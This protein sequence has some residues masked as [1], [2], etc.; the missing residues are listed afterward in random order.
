MCSSTVMR[1][2]T[3]LA[4]S[5]LRQASSRSFVLPDVLRELKVPA[6]NTTTARQCK[7]QDRFARILPTA[8]SGEVEISDGYY[9]K[10]VCMT[11]T[12]SWS[13][14]GGAPAFAGAN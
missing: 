6:S 2:G 9:F 4:G 13:R 8:R 1:A 7:T 14:V 10:I 5:L 3:A 11:A 12:V